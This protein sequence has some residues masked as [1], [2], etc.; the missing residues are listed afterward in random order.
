MYNLFP[1]VEAARLSQQVRSVLR[2]AAG[3]PY[4]SLGRNFEPAIVI[5]IPF[6]NRRN[7]SLPSGVR[8]YTPACSSTLAK[9][10]PVSF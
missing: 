10:R 6:R 8:L 7:A 2:A 9:T 1:S 5:Y 3:R 4:S